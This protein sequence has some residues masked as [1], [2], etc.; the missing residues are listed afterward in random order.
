M[1]QRSILK[2][3]GTKK[4]K[5]TVKI[6]ATNRLRIINPNYLHYTTRK[7]KRE[8][9]IKHHAVEKPYKDVYITAKNKSISYGI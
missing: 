7:Q 2:K 8:F 1:G 4:S 6:S 5:K 9:P 3:T